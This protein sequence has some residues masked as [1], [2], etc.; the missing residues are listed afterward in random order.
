MA[1]TNAAKS[2]FVRHIYFLW[3]VFIFSFFMKKIVIF[4]TNNVMGD[5]PCKA[6]SYKKL[7]PSSKSHSSSNISRRQAAP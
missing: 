7:Y 6:V 1:E 4:Q 2:E 5:S 3:R